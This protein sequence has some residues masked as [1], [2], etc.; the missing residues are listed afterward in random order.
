MILDNRIISKVELTDKQDKRIRDLNHSGGY[1]N[2]EQRL[3]LSL[4]GGGPA[5]KPKGV[6]FAA[7]GHFFIN[8]IPIRS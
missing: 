8:G 5:L 7:L 6:A 2:V 3:K 1:V 4:C